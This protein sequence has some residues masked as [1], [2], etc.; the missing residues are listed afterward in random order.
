MKICLVTPAPDESRCGNRVT[1]ER[2]S[3]ILREL[4][5]ET[6]VRERWDGEACNLL[7][8]LHARKSASS[9]D[10]YLEA[11]SGAP[12]IVCG[13]GTDLYADPDLS[14]IAARSFARATRI[15]VLQ[16]EAIHAL[17][18]ETR[19]RARTVFQSAPSAGPPLAV[20][21]EDADVFQVCALG[22]LREVKDPFLLADAL[23][24]L[25][26]SSR[27]RAVQAGAPIDAGTRERALRE[28]ADNP[29]YGWLGELSHAEAQ[30][31]LRGSRL[32]ILT[33]RAE[34]GANVVSE[35]LAAGVPVI[36]TRIA[37]TIGLLGDDYPGLFPVGEA[38]AL[39]ALLQ[40]GES[41]PAF[42]TRLSRWCEDRSDLVR[43][44]R[45]RDAWRRLLQEILAAGHDGHADRD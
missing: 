3:R 7:I 42:M 28:T 37:G 22:H 38:P 2:W 11:G 20:D 25:P 18:A 27:V 19:E 40:R 33:S 31:V 13:T 26:A 12:L 9:I 45:E 35:A 15:V 5:H 16:P 4:G 41:E 44:E 14:A 1:A 36:S 23:R 30:D 10:R 43:P 24:L 29:R 34:G 17:P 39:A 32:L 21:T 8:A 6:F